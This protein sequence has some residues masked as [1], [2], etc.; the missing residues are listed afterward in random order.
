S[1]SNLWKSNLHMPLV[2]HIVRQGTYKSSDIVVL[3]PYTGQ[4]QKLRAKVR[5]ECG[6]VL[7]ERDQEVSAKMDS[8]TK[9]LA[10]RMSVKSLVAFGF[11]TKPRLSSA[12]LFQ[13]LTSA[14]DG[15]VTAA[16]TSA[17]ALLISGS[18]S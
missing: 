8:S 16:I 6:I 18:N 9:K 11:F 14:P 10:A 12:L 4:L 15:L 3:T 5:N 2:R 7:N 17:P 13:R 1:Y